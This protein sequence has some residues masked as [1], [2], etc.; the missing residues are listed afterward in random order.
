[1]VCSCPAL[2]RIQTDPDTALAIRPTATNLS[3]AM[4]ETTVANPAPKSLAIRAKLGK[5][6]QAFTWNSTESPVVLVRERVKVATSGLQITGVDQVHNHIENSL[7]RDRVIS[8]GFEQSVQIERL[9]AH[10]DEHLKHLAC[11]LVHSR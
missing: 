5:A 9:A 4:Y 10:L 3:A 7:T 1:M 6:K 8:P 2:D 11:Q